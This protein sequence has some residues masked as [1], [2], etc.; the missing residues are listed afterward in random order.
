[1]PPDNAQGR[2]WAV[3]SIN[4]LPGLAAVIALV[5]TWQT[6]NQANADLRLSEE[7]QITD[8]Y[9]SAVTNLGSK[10]ETLR[11]GGVYALQRIMQDS[12]RDQPAIVNLLSSF[13]RTRAPI[14]QEKTKIP[15]DLSI[16]VSDEKKSGHHLRL[17]ADIQAAI[18]VLTSRDAARDK[19]AVVD[20]RSSDLRGA[21]LSDRDLKGFLFTG[22]DLRYSHLARANLR[23]ANLVKA[24]LDKAEMLDADLRKSTLQGASFRGAELSTADL[25]GSLIG[26]QIFLTPT[27]LGF[28]SSKPHRDL[29][30]CR[31][32][33]R[34]SL[35]PA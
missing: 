13:V 3:I 10:T 24:R 31:R 27:C 1:M 20:L 28:V 35:P 23:E 7:G 8:R 2:D 12:T 11:L 19:S 9:N 14:D 18:E 29:S 26:G 25:S 17:E 5:F 15:D 6:V 32:S 33:P 16:P 30:P 22:S 4:L 21:D 34:F